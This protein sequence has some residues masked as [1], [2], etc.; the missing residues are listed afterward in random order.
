MFKIEYTQ[1]ARQDLKT[2]RKFQQQII[3][4]GIDQHL[5]LEPTV[6]T[7]NRKRMRP[8]TISD[9]ELRLR[10]YRVFYNVEEQVKIVVIQA[11]G[12]KV[13]NEL[14]IRGERRKL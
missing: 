13:R 6:E 12:F 11:V 5:Q 4:D 7:L 3:V 10:K 2:L 1:S 14:Y 9:W 8:N